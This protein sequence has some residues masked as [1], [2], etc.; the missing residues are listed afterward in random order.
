MASNRY[1]EI[2]FEEFS[3]I[4]KLLFKL[5]AIS[6]KKKKSNAGIVKLSIK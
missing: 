4:F 3:G 2:N 1:K 5:T 6:P